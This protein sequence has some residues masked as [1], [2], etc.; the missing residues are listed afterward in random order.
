[1]SN[2]ILFFRQCVGQHILVYSLYSICQV[3]QILPLIIPT[4]N[5][6][7]CSKV[8]MPPSIFT[9][10]VSQTIWLVCCFLH[11]VTLAFFVI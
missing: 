4:L 11:I 3:G 7:L 6:H 10:I 5:E 9:L 2:F 8:L 1:M